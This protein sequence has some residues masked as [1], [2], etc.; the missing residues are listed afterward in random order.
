MP[1]EII[2]YIT[3]TLLGLM[4]GSFLNAVIYR[5][6]SGD[7]IVKERSKCPSCKQKLG[8]IDLVPVFS[9]LYLKG[10]CRFCKVGISWQY[11]IIEIVTTALFVIG[12]YYFGLTGELIAF[13]VL[14][15][16]MIVIFT[17]DLKH[18]LILDKVTV[19]GIIIA[20]LFALFI[21]QLTF[22]Q[23]FLGAII[24][25]GIFWLQYALSKGK[26]V[27][28]GDIRLG[29]MMGIF[30]G[31]EKL[32]VA[33]FLA[34]IIGAIVAIAL[35]LGGKKGMKSQLPFGTFLAASAVIT[36]LFGDQIINWYLSL[37]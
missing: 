23:I 25:G 9:F 26:W 7:S 20:L 30:L 16:F 33:L 24:G 21:Y 17:Y 2:L 19:P 6:K 35:I 29:L 28:G 31:W 15:C 22:W 34:Y 18:Y 12:Y 32:L 10:K 5:L 13:W 11:P 3:I 14:T 4:V 1:N 8:P 27:G 36:L 37:L